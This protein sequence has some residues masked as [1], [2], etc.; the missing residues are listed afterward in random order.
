MHGTQ[1]GVRGFSP[2]SCQAMVP[3]GFERCWRGCV[4]HRCLI[5]NGTLGILN[6]SMRTFL[7]LASKIKNQH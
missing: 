2:L 1:S 7:L 3:L 6:R 4:D 5:G